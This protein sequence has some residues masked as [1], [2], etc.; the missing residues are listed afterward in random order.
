MIIMKCLDKIMEIFKDS[1]S[2]SLEE[3]RNKIPLDENELNEVLDFLLEQNFIKKIEKNLK[4]T[5]L[6]LKLLDLPSKGL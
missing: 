3:L 2:H 6:G 1:E 4:I 5:P